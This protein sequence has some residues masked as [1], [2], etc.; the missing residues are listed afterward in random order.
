MYLEQFRKLEDRCPAEEGSVVQKIVAEDLG[1]SDIGEIFKSF[2]PTPIGAAS[3]GQVHRAVLKDGTPVCVKVQYPGVE[4]LFRS[5]IDTCR[6]FCRFVAPEQLLVFDEIQQQFMAEFNYRVEAEQLE[7]ALRNMQPFAA[8]VHVPKPFMDLC[9]RNV[10]VMEFIE[11]PKLRDG[12]R[13]YARKWAARQGKTLEQLSLEMRQE[14]ELNGLPP[15]YTGPSA[16]TIETYRWV[17]RSITYM[18]NFP[19]ALCNKVTNLLG[20]TSQFRLFDFEIPLNGS[21]IMGTLGKITAHQIFVDGFVNA[22]PHG[23]N[24]LLMPDGRIGLIDFGQVKKLTLKERLYLAKV[25]CFF[26]VLLQSNKFY[27]GP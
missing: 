10:L 7:Q 8:E 9:T 16:R 14:F 15:P 25:L 1:V 2:D 23:G 17:W 24:F 3:I 11:G 18:V 6:F 4:T 12:I 26:P 21:M 13:N 5:D 27:Q 20:K 19:I 22:D